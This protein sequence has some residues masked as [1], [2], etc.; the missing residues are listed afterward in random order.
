M[1]KQRSFQA[2]ALTA[3]LLL[4]PSCVGTRSAG[5]V[6]TVTATSFNLLGLQIPFNDYEEANR[7]VPPGA[8]VET[9][10]S[11][12]RDWSSLIGILTSILGFT[13]TQVSYVEGT[14][15]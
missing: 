14:G 7:M 9:V 5:N 12:P 6:T 10:I 2:I 1:L 3:A 8:R 15:N 4:L 13:N 11:Q